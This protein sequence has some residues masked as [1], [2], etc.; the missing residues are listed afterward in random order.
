[1][2]YSRDAKLG[3]DGHGIELACLYTY[4]AAALYTNDRDK[5]TVAGTLIDNDSGTP[6]I[7][8]IMK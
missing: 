1:M 6:G 7:C 5:S 3:L 4:W 8:L 2:V